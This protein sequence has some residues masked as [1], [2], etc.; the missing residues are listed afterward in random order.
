MSW[1]ACVCSH[2]EL[3]FFLSFRQQQRWGDRETGLRHLSASGYFSEQ[4]CLCRNCITLYSNVLLRFEIKSIGWRGFMEALQVQIAFPPED[5]WCSVRQMLTLMG[6]IICFIKTI[7]NSQFFQ[8]GHWCSSIFMNSIYF[9]LSISLTLRVMTLSLICCWNR[10]RNRILV[11]EFQSVC[12]F[13][14]TQ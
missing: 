8:P 6:N 4:A 1:K 13:I 3:I 9:N 11:S 7:Y 5:I 2:R 14:Y 12:V 10:M